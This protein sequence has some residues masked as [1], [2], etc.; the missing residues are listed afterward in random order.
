MIS[1]QKKT[2]IKKT[3]PRNLWV[4]NP[5]TKIKPNAKKEQEKTSC[6]TNRRKPFHTPDE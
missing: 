6:R 1:D 4:R 5:V 2:I 3:T